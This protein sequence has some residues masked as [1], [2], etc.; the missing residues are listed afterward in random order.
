[1]F[2]N[3]WNQKV[4]QH[5]PCCGSRFVTVERAF[6]GHDFSVA[7]DSPTVNLDKDEF[8]FLFPAK[9]CLKKM[10]VGKPQKDKFRSFNVPHFGPLF[11]RD[12]NQTVCSEAEKSVFSVKHFVLKSHFFVEFEPLL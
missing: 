8:P 12:G 1:M 5:A 2:E 10:N 7:A 6:I 9:A 3:E 11:I 4:F